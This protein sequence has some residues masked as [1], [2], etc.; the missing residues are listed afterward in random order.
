MLSNILQYVYRKTK[1]ERDKHAFCLKWSP[2]FCC[3]LALFL[4]MA[5]LTRHLANDAWGTACDPLAEGSV[6]AFK[7]GDKWDPVDPK[8]SKLC[9]SRNVMDEYTNGHLSAWGWGF[10]VVCTWAGFILLFVGIFWAIELPKKLAAQWRA[11]RRG[12]NSAR[13]PLAPG[14]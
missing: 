11:I 7:T 1:Q 6:L 13:Q 5:D 9:Y 4:T 8:Y 12:R 10:S 3:V 2:F 14:V